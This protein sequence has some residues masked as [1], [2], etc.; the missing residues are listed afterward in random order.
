MDIKLK[1]QGFSLV[2]LS[3][4][5][6]IIALL[7]ASIASGASLNKKA[8]L[9][10]VIH[11]MES[12]RLAFNGFYD[13][14]HAVPGDMSNAEFYFPTCSVSPGN[15]NGNGNDIINSDDGSG[16]ESLAAW[17]ELSIANMISTNIRA[18][19]DSPGSEVVNLSMPASKLKYLYGSKAGYIIVGAGA[20]VGDGSNAPVF[21]PWSDNH[22][23]SVFL[24]IPTQGEQGLAT[25]ALTPEDA[26]T[27]DQKMDD[28]TI[29]AS[30]GFSGATTGKF[31]SIQGG[32]T[33]TNCLSGSNYDLTVSS[34]TC[35]SG[36]ALN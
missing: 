17:R 11:D 24:G 35:I 12:Y 28:G 9:D 7:I 26:Y 13:R 5:L 1:T 10:S 2:E 32:D 29:N 27:I 14:Y 18:V 15:C 30:G 6:V 34:V 16:H 8:T 3:M 21:S 36:F 23:N 33:S 31:R 20:R 4:V 19:V 25:S 22:T